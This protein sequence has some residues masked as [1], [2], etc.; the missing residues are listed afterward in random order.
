MPLVTGGW[1][2]KNS[3]AGRATPTHATATHP[4]LEALSL[5]DVCLGPAYLRVSP[6]AR[7]VL[8]LRLAVYSPHLRDSQA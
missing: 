7:Y 1:I 3:G 6:S 2:L 5:I 8:G 4:Q